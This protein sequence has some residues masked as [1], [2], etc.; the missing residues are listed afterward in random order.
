M[1]RMDD[2]VEEIKLAKI[3]FK[4]DDWETISEEA[5]DLVKNLLAKDPN[6]RYSPFQALT[7]PWV[8]NVRIIYYAFRILKTP[9]SIARKY[10]IKIHF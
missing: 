7:H 3:D 6:A 10:F 8:V 1:I 5:K 9:F 4:D 2:I